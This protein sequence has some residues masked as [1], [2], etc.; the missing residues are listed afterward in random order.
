MYDCQAKDA[1]LESHRTGCTHQPC[2]GVCFGGSHRVEGVMVNTSEVTTNCTL[3]FPM[4]N[5]FCLTVVEEEGQGEE[6]PQ[7]E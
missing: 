7:R 1:S 3:G 2:A 5:F 6:Q 4:K